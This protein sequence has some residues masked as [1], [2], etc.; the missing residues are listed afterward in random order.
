MKNGIQREIKEEFS[1]IPELLKKKNREKYG[2][3]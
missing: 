3:C 1:E 2:C